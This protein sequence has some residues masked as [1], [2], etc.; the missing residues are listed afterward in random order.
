MAVE[1]LRRR[2]FIFEDL[3]DGMVHQIDPHKWDAYVRTTWPEIT[4]HFP[5]QAEVLCVMD[6]GGVFFGPFAGWER[7]A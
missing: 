3:V 7:E 4:S 5:S 1:E 6:A 2:G